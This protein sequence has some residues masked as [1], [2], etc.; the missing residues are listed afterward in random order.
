MPLA[1]RNELNTV[2]SFQTQF[3]FFLPDYCLSRSENPLYAIQNVI[4]LAE[5]N[6]CSVNKGVFM[7]AM[8]SSSSYFS[9]IH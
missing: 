6:S 8:R 1:K 9:H 7:T 2:H 3:I 5:M 4:E